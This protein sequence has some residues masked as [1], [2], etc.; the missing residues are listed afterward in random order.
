MDLKAPVGAFSSRGLRKYLTMDILRSFQ[1]GRGI[2][3]IVRDLAPAYPSL[4][5]GKGGLFPTLSRDTNAQTLLLHISSRQGKPHHGKHISGWTRSTS[6]PLN[7][8]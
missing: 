6:L 3:P 1:S 4:T 7:A 5:S 8:L 2:G